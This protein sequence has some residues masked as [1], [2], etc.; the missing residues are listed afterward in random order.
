MCPPGPPFD[1]GTLPPFFGGPLQAPPG[2]WP[3]GFNPSLEAPNTAPQCFIQDSNSALPFFDVNRAPDEQ[4][5]ELA[6]LLREGGG[7]PMGCVEDM[8]AFPMDLPA[9]HPDVFGHQASSHGIPL[10]PP[11]S[12]PPPGARGDEALA[13][14]RRHGVEGLAPSKN[15]RSGGAVTIYSGYSSVTSAMQKT[16]K[17]AALEPAQALLQQQQQRQANPAGA[18]SGREALTRQLPEGWE[19]KKSRTTGKTYYVNEKLGTSQFEPP[20]GSTVKAESTKKKHKSQIPKTD[21][22]S[23]IKGDKNGVLGLVRASSARTGRFAKWNRCNEMV[24]AEDEPED[25]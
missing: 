9:F 20:H 13:K 2:G 10:A 17:A 25:Q 5:A 8:A 16:P 12:G 1:S 24:H 15:I 18:V 21:A 3:P 4:A 23:A 14:K 6:I 22:P 11:P 19:M 7:L